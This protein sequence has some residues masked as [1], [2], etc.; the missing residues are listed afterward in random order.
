MDQ[1]LVK[2]YKNFFLNSIKNYFIC[3]DMIQKEID[4][5]TN[6]NLQDGMLFFLCAFDNFDPDYFNKYNFLNKL[7][8]KNYVIFDDKNYKLT[9]S[10]RDLKFFLEEKLLAQALML[11]FNGL[12]AVAVGRLSTMLKRFQKFWKILINHSK[13]F[14]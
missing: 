10:G 2:G 12:N 1:E 5:H 4:I 11:E 8:F 13:T 7:Q 6:Y 9:Q 3:Y 14:S